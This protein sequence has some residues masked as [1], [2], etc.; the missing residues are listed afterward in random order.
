MINALV[1]DLRNVADLLTQHADVLDRHH[2]TFT[3]MGVSFHVMTPD[4]FH[5]IA[6][7]FG[8]AGMFEHSQIGD[9]GSTYKAELKLGSCRIMLLGSSENLCEATPTTA[10]SYTLKPKALVAA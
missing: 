8:G 5:E 1:A 6:D 7:C 4:A 2:P 10:F 3:T 9:G